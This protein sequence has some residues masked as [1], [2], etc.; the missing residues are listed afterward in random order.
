MNHISVP[1]ISAKLTL[2]IRDADTL[3]VKR[4][5]E[6]TNTITIRGYIGNLFDG[7]KINGGT[8]STVYM[9]AIYISADNFA[10]GLHTLNAV[11]TFITR[12]N[13]TVSEW[14]WTEG[15]PDYVQKTARF[16][17]PASQRTIRTIYLGTNG[18]SSTT[19][20][21]AISALSTPCIQ[22]TNEVLDVT[23]RIQFYYYDSGGSPIN[24]NVI[25][26]S[27]MGY[28]F[29]KWFSTGSALG[30]P[31]YGYQHLCGLPEDGNVYNVWARWGSNQK[32]ATWAGDHTY[33]RYNFDTTNSVS[34]DIGKIARTIEITS[35]ADGNDY[36]SSNYVS[37]TWSSVFPSGSPHKPIQPIHNHNIDAISPFLD[38]DFLASSQGSVFANGSAWTNLDWPELYRIEYTSTGDV[39][40]ARYMARMRRTVGFEGESYESDRVPLS[41]K[42]YHDTLA[43]KTIEGGYG[44]GKIP[45]HYFR[46]EQ[47][48]KD[49]TISWED[50]GGITLINHNTSVVRTF[51]ADSNPALPVSS[52]HQVSVDNNDNIWIAA[53]SQG[54]FRI[55]DP[56]GTP[57][58]TQMNNATNGLPVVGYTQCYAVAVGYNNSIW[59]LCSNGLVHTLNPTDPNPSFVI[60][61][62]TTTGVPF[63]YTGITNNN[64]DDVLYMDVDRNHPDNQM[65]FAL[66]NLGGTN[67]QLAWWSTQGVS[68]TGPVLQS[69]TITA[70]V[71]YRRAKCS[72]YGNAWVGIDSTGDTATYMKRLVFGQSSFGT[73]LYTSGYLGG[74]NGT[75]CWFYDNYNVPYVFGGGS[76][77][78]SSNTNYHCIALFN[79]DGKVFARINEIAKIESSATNGYIYPAQMSFED[80][81]LFVHTL[82]YTTNHHYPFHVTSPAA[83]DKD[84]GTIDS[85]NGRYSPFEELMWDKYHWNGAAWEKNYYAPALDTSTFAGGPYPGARMNFDT[86][87]H[88]FTGR[89][90]IDISDVFALNNFAGGSP[91]SA[92]ATFAFRIT[93][94]AK[95]DGGG[96]TTFSHQELPRILIDISTQTQKF[97]VYWDN[98]SSS[99]VIEDTAG[100]H[101]VGATSADDVTYRVVVT[102]NGTTCKVYVDGIQL[103][104]DV[105]LN[106][107]YDWSNTNQDLKCYIG[108][109]VYSWS[110]Q[111]I[112][113]RPYY[114]YSGTMTNVQIW[115]VEWD[116]TD[117][118]DDA[119]DPINVIGS[120][121]IGNL[122][123]RYQL[124][125]SLAGLETKATHGTYEP[126][127]NGITV[128]MADGVSGDSFVATD[129]HTFGVVDGVLKDNAISYNYH[130]GVYIK[131][132][133]VGFSEV[134]NNS[135]GTTVSA[136]TVTATERI[137]FG[138]VSSATYSTIWTIPGQITGAANSNGWSSQ[139]IINNGY[140]EC[141]PGL[142]NI[143]AYFGITTTPAA[144]SSNTIMTHAFRFRTT[145]FVDIYHGATQT[146]A[147]VST[148]TNDPNTLYRITRTGSTITYEK[149]VSGVPTTLYTSLVASSNTIYANFLSVVTPSVITDCT[150]N[151][152]RPGY[153]MTIGNSNTLTGSF[154]PGFSRVDTE[155]PENIF[156]HTTGSPNAFDV[157]ISET[158]YGAMTLPG[159]GEVVLNG[160][161]G[162]LLF[163]AADVGTDIV[164]ASFNVVYDKM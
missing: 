20:C 119:A 19:A 116:S 154:K 124:T 117:V 120:K 74:Y 13:S 163:N 64:W 112:S 145:G 59:A 159:P 70:P 100:S 139:P 52:V 86:E 141:R 96:N 103:G 91:T 1:T 111:K 34:T 69:Y 31:Q 126:L 57:T 158:Y 118:S 18:V 55:E 65:L 129:Y 66:N 3:E 39:G 61:D 63:D 6:E 153:I 25:T 128:A 144:S 102:V 53:P 51:D 138:D 132:A 72:K 152:V 12:Q 115:N 149:V 14:A 125:D 162:W 109:R 151:Y 23:Y 8:D 123:A 98:G 21:G 95:Y 101:T 127:L 142:D 71:A 108:S 79:M 105:T 136:S 164:D 157:I 150:I 94:T 68:Y 62:P 40:V 92:T 133:D 121:P 11:K 9:T 107:A 97:R 15:N 33:G 60:Y 161:T 58:I 140:V 122:V 43:Y 131:P 4:T 88:T 146:V 28:Y 76:S 56:Y 147:S 110:D 50:S 5:Q 106:A 104:S 81:G 73:N 90:L 36:I 67:V 37:T 134:V 2:Q 42:Y 26:K 7:E 47:Y 135:F 143:D 156:V 148:Y 38:V 77:P 24:S 87:S 114:F 160:K 32:Y 35:D 130:F 80:S 82:R 22:E 113:H 75:I 84:W 27:S 29:A 16:T 54:L 48:G 30:F 45:S 10:S 49:S 89:S 44:L 99:V 85:L 17:Q 83:Y 41:T 46:I 78:S 137:V 155:Y 93:P